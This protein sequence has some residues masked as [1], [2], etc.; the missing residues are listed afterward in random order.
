MR[1]PSSAMAAPS[2]TWRGRSASRQPY[3]VIF[4][5]LRARAPAGSPAECLIRAHDARFR[6]SRADHALARDC[7]EAVVAA[8]PSYHLGYA[9][10][11]GFYLLEHSAGLNPRP[12]PLD[13]AL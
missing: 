3:G 2:A 12:A 10:L 7:L 11:T 1:G 9:L 4:S 8:N 6:V 13:R 5:D